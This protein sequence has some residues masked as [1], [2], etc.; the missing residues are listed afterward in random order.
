[1]MMV[2]MVGMMMTMMMM[3]MTIAMATTTLTMR[4][5]RRRRRRKLKAVTRGAFR[6]DLAKSSHGAHLGC[7]RAVWCSCGAVLGA[8]WGLLGPF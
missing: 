1:M 3:A 4:R 7:L 2:M 5:R 6:F 8:P